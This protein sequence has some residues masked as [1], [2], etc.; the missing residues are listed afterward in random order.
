LT[1][2]L[3]DRPVQLP[4]SGTA[5]ALLGLFGWRLVFDGLPARQGVLVMYPHTSNWDFVWSM[6]ARWATG[7]RIHFWAKDSLFKVPL[8][9]HWLRWLGGV[10]VDRRAPKGA[11]GQMVQRLEQ[12]RTDGEFLWLAL[13]PE[14]TRLRREAWRSGFHQ[15][16]LQ[17]DVPLALAFIDYPNKRVGIQSFLRLS[18]D[19]RADMAAI[20]GQIGHHQ[21][22]H[23]ELA[24]PIRLED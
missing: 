9:G 4:G 14:G 5:R 17:A 21:G 12:C 7:M 2:L 3:P 23:P 19:R 13:A 6:L 16:A 1:E 22:R 20:A 15:V 24:T 18:G 10:A 11:V 8:F